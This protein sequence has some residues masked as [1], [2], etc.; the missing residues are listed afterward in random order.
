MRKAGEKVADAMFKK[1]EPID[2]PENRE[3]SLQ[4]RPD[5]RKERDIRHPFGA[6]T[7]L[8]WLFVTLTICNL[9]WTSCPSGHR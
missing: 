4:Q 6:N 5:L 2:D 7:Q 3:Q 8:R 9:M 1:Q